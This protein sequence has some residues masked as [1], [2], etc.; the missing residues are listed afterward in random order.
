[1]TS[2]T[3]IDKKPDHHFHMSNIISFFLCVFFILGFVLPPCGAADDLCPD[4]PF[5]TGPGISGCGHAEAMVAAGAAHSMALKSDGMVW[6]WG[7]NA[8]GQV[9]VEDGGQVLAPTQ[10]EKSGG[11]VL[12]GVRIIAAGGY[13]SL[14]VTAD[15]YVWAWG[16]NE[17]GQLGDGANASSYIP[18]QVK[19]LDGSL[20][21]GVRAVAGG[22]CHSLAVK[23]NGTVR[24]W[25]SN[26]YGQL[27][28]GSVISSSNPV[29][30]VMSD[31]HS[32]SGIQAVAGGYGHSLALKTDGTVWAWGGNK[33]GQLGDGE[34]GS[35]SN[36]VQVIASA[37]NP[38]TDVMAIAAG[39]NFS[40]ALKNDGTVWAWGWNYYGQLGN[41]TNEESHT[42]KQVIMPD[43]SPLSEVVAIA[44][45]GMHA[46]A[47]KNDGAVWGWGYNAKGQLGNGDSTVSYY[48]VQASDISGAY[49]I[50]GG[51][52][53]SL[54]IAGEGMVWAWGK[55]GDGQLGTGIADFVAHPVPLNVLL[56]G[57]NFHCFSDEDGDSV[58]DE[59]LDNCP[60]IINPDQADADN[61]G[62]GNLCDNCPDSYNPLQEDSDGDSL[63]DA[64]DNCP[65][66]NNPGQE[67]ADGD[68]LGDA[69]DSCPDD[70][71]KAEP[72]ISGCGNAKA[73][74]SAGR[75]HSLAL[76]SDGAVWAWGRNEDGQIGDGSTI[77]KPNPVQVVMVDGSSFTGIQAIAA[78]C[79]HSLALKNDGAVWAWGGN[80]YGQLGSASTGRKRNPVQTVMTDGSLLIGII[81]IVA[82][83]YHSLALK[84]DGAVWAWGR[85][86]HGQ[87]GDGSTIDKPNPVQVVTADGSP[88]TGII[89]IAAGEYHSLGLKNDGAVW[90][91]GRNED[92]Q[93]GDGSTI[94]KPN[95]VQ[96]VMAD[97]SPFTGVQAIA[98][99]YRH[100]L[101]LKNDGAVWAW[102]RNTLGQIGDGSTISKPN[103]V[104]V[105]MADGSPI[106]DVKA[107]AAGCRHSLALKSD[108]AVWAWGYN[109][110]GQLGDGETDSLSNPV[111][112]IAS[113]DNPLTDVMAIAA[114]DN[115]SLALKN[116]GAVWAWGWNYCGQLGIGDSDTA[117]H[118][119]PVNVI[120]SKKNFHCFFD[121]DG[122]GL[123]DDLLDNCPSVPN[124]DQEDTDSDGV[125]GP[126]DNC[127]LIAN[128]DQ[129]DADS[130]GIGDLC[131]NCPH[132]SNPE[133]TDI[134]SDGRADACDNCGAIYNPGQEDANNDGIGNACQSD[135]DGDGLDDE[136]DN[137]PLVANGDQTDTDGDRLGNAC[138]PDDDND[139]LNDDVDN[140]PLI[141]N[142][143][144]LNFDGDSLG[145]A[146]DPDDDNDGIDNHEDNCPLASN[147]DQADSDGDGQG[148]VC[149]NCPGISNPD[150]TDT[151]GDGW[152]NA[153]QE[154]DD[155]DGIADEEDNC[156][157]IAN[158]DQA[159][160][161]GDNVGDLCDNC[162]GVF[163]SNREDTDNDGFGDACDNCP[164]IA[165]PDQA[166]RDGDNTGDVCD[167]CRYTPNPDQQD[168]DGNGTG[169]A[170]PGLQS[171]DVNGNGELDLEDAI[172][173]L[174]IAT[175]NYNGALI[176]DN[177]LGEDG[178]FGMEE[179]LYVLQGLS[180]LRETKIE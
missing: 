67:D 100:T 126:C 64:C 17:S 145:N 55:N 144:Q 23:A 171:C 177:A 89:A 14:A 170:C 109:R 102:G 21:F 120:L 106:A 35:L 36:P 169:D 62:I 7:G 83:E 162:P 147:A 180:G 160:S 70:P 1:M 75:I 33:Y 47:L 93:I 90:A 149:D 155:G 15:G 39:E 151:N 156:P 27:G 30:V 127:P 50:A 63:S 68:F 123:D 49:A 92:G 150:Q 104:Q 124:P 130:D 76:K 9:G 125:G 165:N 59:F 44:G 60:S 71:F 143:D 135:D 96:V 45:T 29:E 22:D 110:Y 122:D 40:L 131:D 6:V 178:V 24:A 99:R 88:L 114:G 48:P 81:A 105:V 79:F 168:T 140:C 111:Q 3:P 112:V 119:N 69:C 141:F 54:A 19:L 10:V 25:G 167:N 97:G 154:D 31:A 8:F 136:E 42:A 98:A 77:D 159:D 173:C 65:N 13:H 118:P 57:E 20:L 52:R 72:G 116:D 129:A 158:A 115:F 16:A 4:D 78:G 51:E 26:S 94:D 2:L 152:G 121:E 163:N 61:D 95:P 146:C 133:Q 117:S 175:I 157:L 85:N 108:G 176:R 103:P 84:S 73:V 58:D 28:D 91:W 18:S 164:A 80:Y 87:I 139:G 5:K 86:E 128:P 137:C 161:D 43:Q 138:D 101:A 11:K 166:D 37:D 174:Q 12:S 38:L 107:I 172:I 53:H 46:L 142:S 134:D 74:L 148:N 34:T 113:E 82:G 153:C 132:N 32:L 41:G 56:S 179:A 66:K